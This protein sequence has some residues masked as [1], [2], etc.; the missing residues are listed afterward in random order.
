[1]ETGKKYLSK[2]RKKY[3]Y[4][5]TTVNAVIN[6]NETNFFSGHTVISKMSPFRKKFVDAQSKVNSDPTCCIAHG[7]LILQNGIHRSLLQ[8]GIRGSLN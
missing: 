6:C 2:K 5:F 7:P 1:M 8:N 3:I 4:Y